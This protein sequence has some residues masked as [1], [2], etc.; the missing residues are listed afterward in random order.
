MLSCAEIMLPVKPEDT[1]PLF[2][3]T[4]STPGCRSGHRE[5][6]TKSGHWMNRRVLSD[7]F[8]GI[9]STKPTF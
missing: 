7:S 9:G 3:T 4:T 6:S 8:E 5:V 2:D 1:G